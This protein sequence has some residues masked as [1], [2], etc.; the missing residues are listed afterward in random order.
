MEAG[1]LAREAPRVVKCLH[2]RVGHPGVG[3]GCRWGSHAGV[4]PDDLLGPQGAAAAVLH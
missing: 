1:S 2:V 4:R 3:D